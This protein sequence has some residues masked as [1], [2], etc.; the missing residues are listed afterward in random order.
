MQRSFLSSTSTRRFKIRKHPTSKGP[1]FKIYEHL[2][3]KAEPPVEKRR[4]IYARPSRSES[5]PSVRHFKPPRSIPVP[6]K[7][8]YVGK[9]YGGLES[10]EE[11]LGAVTDTPGNHSLNRSGIAD[12]RS[13]MERED[14][15]KPGG[16]K[17][18]RWRIDP[19]GLASIRNKPADSSF[20]P[21][22]ANKILRL[23]QK[24]DALRSQEG[25]NRTQKGNRRTKIKRLLQ[26]IERAKRDETG[27]GLTREQIN[28][29]RKLRA[30][31]IGKRLPPDGLRSKLIE[32]P[33]QDG[34]KGWN[35]LLSKVD[36]E[37]KRD[38]VH[39]TAVIPIQRTTRRDDVGASSLS[40]FEHMAGD[41]S[42]TR[43]GTSLKPLPWESEALPE[44][45]EVVGSLKPSREQTSLVGKPLGH[46]TYNDPQPT[47]EELSLFE[48]L[49]PE[50]SKQSDA[51]RRAEERLDKLP[52]FEWDLDE[53]FDESWKAERERE[54]ER[55]HTIPMR[56]NPS[57]ASEET[58]WAPVASAQESPVYKQNLEHNHM[59]EP[60]VVVLSGVS[61]HLEESDFF[62][63]G[64]KGN[65]IEGWTSGILRGMLYPSTKFA[66]IQANIKQSLQLVI[67]SPSSL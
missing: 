49:F 14:V 34:R 15:Q 48:E 42:K 27:E 6:L 19:E 16:T 37:L 1:V 57:P 36:R 18:T 60:S 29:R 38:T 54:K 41:S 30:Q 23:G 24:L 59:R 5:P 28:H 3:L 9:K 45:P 40:F 33:T 51:V 67:M 63:I 35:S 61:K 47:A 2:D 55:R 44:S 21:V 26:V 4:P 20:T 32:E 64:P 7:A 58:R 43:I 53:R 39:E 12:L 66:N 17:G 65:H 25:L 10:A 52:A 56:E 46:S 11:T 13:R 22:D 8:F 31:K 62:R 50:E